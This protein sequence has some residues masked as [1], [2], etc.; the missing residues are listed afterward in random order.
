M[1]EIKLT[2]NPTPAAEPAVETASPAAQTAV[3]TPAAPEAIQEPVFTPEEQAQIDEFSKQIDVTDTNLV[4][5]YG[6][7]AQQGIAEF[8]D[9]ALENVKTKDLDEVG[10]MIANLVTE[11][12]GFSAD[13]EEK[14]GIFGWFKHQR[15]QG[16]ARSRPATTKAEVNVDKHLR[17][18]G[19]SIRCSFSRT[20]PCST[21]LYEHEPDLLQGT[22]HVHRRRQK[23]PGRGPRHRAPRP[24]WWTRPSST[25]LPEDAQAAKDMAEPL[26]PL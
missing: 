4:F 25:G 17:R 15:Q 7:N 19:I 5:S 11:L 1:P 13:E 24:P 9:T 23:A 22:F 26:R 18:A 8:S 14:K 16:R 6:A 2:L 21:S 3:E 20:S 10:D 12:K